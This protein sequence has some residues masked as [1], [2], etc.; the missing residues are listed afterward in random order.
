[1]IPA[2][3]EIKTDDYT[4]LAGLVIRWRLPAVADRAR[5]TVA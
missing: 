3:I 1:V 5:D 2:S 4:N